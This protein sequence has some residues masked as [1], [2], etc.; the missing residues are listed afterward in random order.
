M[1]YLILSLLVIL[2]NTFVASSA[3][4]EKVRK[5]LGH[6]IQL[7]DVGEAGAEEGLYK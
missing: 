6:S 5:P 4:H 2:E 7:E 3:L 1:K